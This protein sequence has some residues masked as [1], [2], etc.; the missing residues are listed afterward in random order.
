MPAA[1]PLESEISEATIERLVHS[2]YGKVRR[3]EMLGPVFVGAL[4][5]TEAA[6]SAHLER[7]CG[8]WSS[9]MLR[10]GRY[11]GDPFSAHLR[12]QGLRAHMFERW[13]ALF[14]E[15]SA[16]LFE[17]PIAAAF[18]D[19]AERIARSLRMGLFERLPARHPAAA[20]PAGVVEA[21]S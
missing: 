7:L 2:F 19:R 1:Q 17:P 18:C 14:A 8:F 5:E 16:E 9:L 11:R 4:G 6:W 12:V 10:T 15:T 21:G 20:T 3:D 13:L